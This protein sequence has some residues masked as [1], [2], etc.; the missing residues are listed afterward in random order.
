MSR[1]KPAEA[2]AAAAKQPRQIIHVGTVISVQFG[3]VD[4]NGNLMP[5]PTVQASLSQFKAEEF[6]EAFEKI[7]QQRDKLKSES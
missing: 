6:L 2:T 3:Y 4:D 7:S 5:L 1:E